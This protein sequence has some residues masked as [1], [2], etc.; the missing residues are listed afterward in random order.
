MWIIAGMKSPE[1]V[2]YNNWLAILVQVENL[3]KSWPTEGQKQNG[4]RNPGWALDDATTTGLVA[5]P[6]NSA[7]VHGGPESASTHAV[8]SL[9]ITWQSDPFLD[10]DSFDEDYS[11]VVLLTE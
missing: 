8:A 1:S 7:I 6:S 10:G 3:R 4:E 11:N 9:G 5:I 2:Q